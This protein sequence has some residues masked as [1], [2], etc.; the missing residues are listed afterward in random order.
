M[1]CADM[2]Q[3]FIT[4]LTYVSARA[5]TNI[6]CDVYPTGRLNEWPSQRLIY[7]DQTCT[8]NYATL[9]VLLITQNRL[10]ARIRHAQNSLKRFNRAGT[11]IS[12]FYMVERIRV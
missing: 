10:G 3:D 4:I 5:C 11:Q 8:K 6:M 12:T 7:L 9:L 1:F 2:H